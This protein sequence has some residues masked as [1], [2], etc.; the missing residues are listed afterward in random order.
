MVVVLGAVLP[1]RSAISACVP[2]DIVE[3]AGVVQ[4]FLFRRAANCVGEPVSDFSDR[5]SDEPDV[6]G[7]GVGVQQRDCSFV[8]LS[9]TWCVAAHP[10]LDFVACWRPAKC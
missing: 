8:K 10:S 6:S 7:N 4:A 9:K 1:S 3:A 5:V 2:G